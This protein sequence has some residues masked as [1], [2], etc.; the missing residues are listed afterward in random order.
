LKYYLWNLFKTF[1]GEVLVQPGRAIVFFSF[2]ALFILPFTPIHPYAPR[3][4]TLC[5]IFAIYAASW[6]LLLFTGQLSLGHC[7][8]LGM[9]AYAAAI[10]NI[11]L[12]F[13]VPLSI[14]VGA[15]VGVGTGLLV[16]LP[17]LRLRGQY[18]G[19]VTLVVPMVLTGI[20]YAFPD[21]T[22]GE[23]G[24]FG[25]TRISYNQYTVASICFAV[26]V[27]SVL[28]M[29]KLTD[30]ESKIV[31]TGI[32]FSA[33]REDEIGARMAGVNTVKYKVLA[34]AVSGFFAGI[35]GGL[36]AHFLGVVGPS[37]LEFLLALLPVVWSVFGGPHTIW[38]P[39]VGVYILYPFSEILL[40]TVPRLKMIL[41]TG[42]V[43]VMLLFMPEGIGPWIRDK[44]EVRCP[45][46]RIIN[47]TRRK[48]CR[49]CRAELHT[50]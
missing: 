6:D 39:I 20:I 33:I 23:N 32:I 26:M 10:L 43:V 27:P 37:T 19:I 4:L 48:T 22:G 25:I 49:A 34:F 28:I 16:S 30:T 40:I 44:L 17:A 36:Y 50:G 24:I 8:F 45:R 14:L 29:W 31:R 18:L 13:P 38:G 2:L 15:L 47:F 35:A 3:V 5:A 12:G 42:L 46:C 7:A 1:Q 9:S 41:F 21:F 11:K